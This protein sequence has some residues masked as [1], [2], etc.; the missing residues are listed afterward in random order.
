MGRRLNETRPIRIMISVTMMVKI[1]RVV[2]KA[3]IFMS[4][5]P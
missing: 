3:L 4:P 1:G 2:V 5:S